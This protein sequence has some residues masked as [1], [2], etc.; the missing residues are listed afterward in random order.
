MARIN[1]NV[2]TSRGFSNAVNKWTKE[3]EERIDRAKKAGLKD[4]RDALLVAT[5]IDTG[6]LRASLQTSPQGGITAG[7]YQEYGSDYNISSS[8]AVIDSLPPDGRVS[9]VYRAPYARRLEY[10]F[11]GVDS[12][13]RHYNQAGRFWIKHTSARFVSIMRAAATR[14]KNT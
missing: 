1:G 13:G 12:I 8:N 3:T 6:N 11:T 14:F 7:P 2:G 10:G 9:F 5:P 4:F